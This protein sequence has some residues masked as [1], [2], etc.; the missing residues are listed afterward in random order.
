MATEAALYR[1]VAATLEAAITAQRDADQALCLPTERALRQTFGAS[2]VT[3]RAAL[4]LLSD[5]HVLER[6]VGAGTFVGRSPT[7]QA[8]RVLTLSV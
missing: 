5:T 6:R 3:I 7:P 8:I 2:R 1:A 4:R